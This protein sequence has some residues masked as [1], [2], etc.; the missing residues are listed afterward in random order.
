MKGAVV[1]LGGKTADSVGLV[2]SGEHS[3]KNEIW[4]RKSW[5]DC[6]RLGA[7]R[8]VV[9]GWLGVVCDWEEMEVG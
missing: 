8:N 7:G 6:S 4:W 1:Q 9:G 2:G 5:T 3:G